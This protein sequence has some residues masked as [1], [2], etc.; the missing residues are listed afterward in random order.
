LFLFVWG[1][2]P[3]PVQAER[4]SAAAG[5]HSNFRSALVCGVQP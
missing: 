3:F 4:S 5:G 1:W 2:S